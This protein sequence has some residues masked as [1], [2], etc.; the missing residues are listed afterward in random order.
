LNSRK[1]LLVAAVMLLAGMG[2]LAVAVAAQ[3]EPQ[4]DKQLLADAERLVNVHK[5]D[6]AVKRLDQINAGALGL[7]DKG[8]YNS[9]LGKA[10]EGALQKPLDEQAI[11]DGKAAIDQQR[12]GTAVD[13]FDQ[14]AKSPW[15][16]DSDRETAKGLLEMAKERHNRALAGARDLL[17]QGKEAAKAGRLGEARTLVDQIKAKDVRFGFFDRIAMADLEKK[18]AGVAPAAV[19]AAPAAPPATSPP[20]RAPAEA[21]APPPVVEVPAEQPVVVKPPMVEPIVEAPAAQPIVKAPAAQPT[22]KAPAEQPAAAAIT[23]VEKQRSVAE[24]A[25]H[26]EAEEFA[27]LGGAAA[28]RGEY[29]EAENYYRKSLDLWPG[30]ERSEK[31]LADVQRF[32]AEREQSVFDTYGTQVNLQRQAIVTQVEELLAQSARQYRKA[33]EG[34]RPEDYNEAL[35]PLAEADRVID[36]ARILQ[37]EQAEGL[38]EKVYSMRRQINDTSAMAAQERTRKATTEAEAALST[39]MERDKAERERN[40]KEHM[41]QVQELTKSQQYHE[42]ILVLD[43][44]V[45]MDPENEWA[46]MFRDELLHMD[47]MSQQF[48][49]RTQRW[50]GQTEALEDVEKASIHPGEEVLGEVQYLRYPNARTWEELS[51]FRREF[52]KVVQQEP[53]AVSETRRRLQEKID[54]DFAQTSLDNV[55]KYISE[56]QRDLNIVVDPELAAAGIDLAS[57]VVDLKLRRVT[58]ESV[59]KLILGTDLGY[60]VEP[61]Y[62]LITTKQKVQQNLPIVT[63]PVQDLVASIPDFGGQAPR[64][65]IQAITSAA[66]AGGAGGGVANLFGATAPAAAEAGVGPTELQDI[67]TRNVN[68]VADPAVAGWTDEGGPAAINYMNG[69]FIITQTREGHQRVSDLLDKLRRERAIMVSI[70]SRFITVSDDF[71]Q[72][73][74][75]DVDVTFPNLNNFQLAAGTQSQNAA[76]G[77]FNTQP[78]LGYGR[79]ILQEYTQQTIVD[80][81]TGLP[82]TVSVPLTDVFGNNV[83]RLASDPALVNAVGATMSGHPVV[84]GNTTSNGMGTASLL[85]LTGTAFA[86]FLANES[87]LIVSGVFLDDVQVGFLLRAIQADVRTHQLF[88]PRITLFNGQRAYIAVMTVVTYV[89]DVEPVVSDAA[90]GFN[91]TVSAIPVGASLDVKATVSADRRYV[92]MDLR[93]QVADVISFSASDVTA[94]APLS[95]VATSAFQLPVISVQDLR[96]TASVPDG[97]TL[98]LGGSKRMKETRVESGVPILSKIPILNRLFDNRASVRTSENL[99]ILIKPKII[100][101]AEEEHKLGYDDL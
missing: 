96:T 27:N 13:K 29:R 43:R 56:V 95:G 52:T 61:G 36:R 50:V 55:L 7:F 101:Q 17:A 15:L 54:L 28:E 79:P 77:V 26:A 11:A 62:I 78:G 74:T 37:A 39:R 44:L 98:L 48:D 33:A 59:L 89:S 14:A 38:R 60:R 66:G 51:K 10:K 87:G 53:Q 100:I 65:D 94:V 19:A 70:E 76:Q 9:V 6:A 18:V 4:T 45:A 24:Q 12:Y 93:P 25:R 22:V 69:V 42:A 97:G 86:N 47:R 73:I 64:F 91:P 72:D 71:L 83:G 90:V 3:E 1:T 92:Q 31:G 41:Q 63:Y 8:K 5:Y 49:T 57:R 82:V 80:P 32:L 75:L 99:L 20:V 23:A 88:A 40:I 81:T 16:E 30:Y 84:V 58:V 85:P 46:H 34:G 67:I 2:A 35:Q 21:P 68:S